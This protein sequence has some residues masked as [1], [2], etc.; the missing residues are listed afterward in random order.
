[1]LAF[2]TEAL[3]I[4]M[5]RE[6]IT[7]IFEVQKK[8]RWEA[9]NSSAQERIQRLKK[10]REAIIKYEAE[11][12]PAFA[13]DFGKP[14]AEAELSEIYPVLEEI[15]FTIK[16]L[17]NWTKPKRVPTPLP[18]F[19]CRSQV[20]YEAKGQ[21]LIIGP[22]NYP[23]NLV[24]TPLVSAVAAGNVV[25]LRPSNKTQ[26][27]ASVIKAIIQ[28]AFPVNEVAVIGGDTSV[29]DLLLE[30]P[31]DHVFFTGSPRIGRKI[32]AS[33]VKNLSSVTL[34]LGGKSPAIVHK[35]AHLD[36][37]V[38]RLVWASF[39]NAGQTCVA[40][41]YVFVHKDI[42]LEFQSKIKA[43]IKAVFGSN[44]AEREQNM[45][46]AR[47]IDPSSL[48][49]LQNLIS[50]SM[51]SGAKLYCGGNT[52]ATTRFLEPTVLTG[53]QPGHAIMSEEIFG[54]IMPILSY[55]DIGTVIQYIRANDK[56][57]ALYLFSRSEKIQEKVL[58]E[59]TSGGA[60]VNH[61]VIHVG[62]PYLPFGGAGTSGLGNY[63]GFYGYKTFSHEKAVI[64][65]GRLGLTSGLFP[66]YARWQNRATLSLLRWLSR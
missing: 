65:Q 62:N 60:V 20:R 42:E 11:L 34:E 19:G 29:A 44:Y 3:C 23:F 41:D 63:H 32:M 7:G 53:V 46:M 17:K 56:P 54:P 33:A 30:L 28:D 21:V 12:Y 38:D 9:A 18:L 40:P 47:V 64:K 10:L 27:V 22:W 24:M 39:L 1:M 43:R 58:S 26:N 61:A 6:E 2:F 5:K 45:D 55:E 48:C 51:V 50:S 8:N 16:N 4:T 52:N 13:R 66:P 35:D 37:S 59:T 31:F 14:A 36:L 15:K 25:V 57:L 49:R